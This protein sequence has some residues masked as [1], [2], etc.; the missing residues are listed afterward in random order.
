MSEV[1][2]ANLFSPFTQATE[3][4][5]S[6]IGLIHIQHPDPVTY[7]ATVRNA[8]VPKDNDFQGMICGGY[9]EM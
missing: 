2:Y 6:L 5:L 9:I 8:N 7:S 1:C 3:L 4:S